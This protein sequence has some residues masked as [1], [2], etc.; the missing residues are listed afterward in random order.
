MD[1]DI[2][3]NGE[4]SLKFEGNVEKQCKHDEDIWK[5]DW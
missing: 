1:F 5:F 2:Y 4:I 3:D